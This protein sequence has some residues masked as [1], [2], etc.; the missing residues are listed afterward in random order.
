MSLNKDFFERKTNI[1]AKVICDSISEQG[2]RLTTFEIEYPRFIHSEL[3]THRTLSKNSSSSRAIPIQ[4]MIGQI[5]SN[6]ATP[7][8]WGKTKS[9]MQADGE[10]D[11]QNSAIYYWLECLSD[12]KKQVNRLSNLSLH[13]QIPNRLLEPFQMMKVVI[14]GTDWDNFFNLRIHCLSDDTEILTT[15][16]WKLIG[17]VQED[18]EVYSL[19]MINGTLEKSKVVNTVSKK[20][21][22]TAISMK[23]QSVDLLMSLK[24][25][26]VHVEDGV[27]KKSLAEDLVGKKITVPKSVKTQQV[28]D[29]TGYDYNEGFITGFALG[30][31]NVYHKKQSGNR[32]L[33]VCKGGKKSEVAL[34]K[35]K[36]ACTVVYP[37]NKVHT[38]QRTSTILEIDGKN[39]YEDFEKLLSDSSIH[40]ELPSNL[41]EQ[42]LDFLKGVFDGLLYSDGNILN[43]SGGLKFYTSSKH[44]A[45]GFQE[46]CLI[47]GY[48]AT[49]SE[50]NRIGRTSEGI[51]SLGKP[52]KITTKN[53][54][55]TCHVNLNR[56]EPTLKQPLEEVQYDGVFKCVTLDTNGT[57]YVR[58]NGKAVWTGNCDAQPEICMLAYK[59]YKA[60]EESKPIDLKVG[61]WHL[62]YVEKYDIPVT[63]SDLG[64]YEYET[65]YHVFHYDKECEHTVEQVLSLEEAIKY[66]AA[67]CA[68]VSYRTEGMTLEKADK[69]FDMLIKAEV[70]HSSPF[71]HCA[72]PIQESNYEYGVN[73]LHQSTWQD[74]VTHMNK[75]GELCSGNLRGWVQYRHTLNNNTCWK[76]DYNERMKL[77]E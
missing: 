37:N 17:N 23:G 70:V 77:F 8:Y 42:P 22:G 19:N 69:I 67:S 20:S 31:G 6:P 74:G 49:V 7:L 45:D 54:S 46:L 28:F 71:E 32:G 75:S 2:V 29:E 51:D 40:K 4:K 72:T 65:G 48:S 64:G 26:V 57:I 68:S 24:H 62:P 59:I 38:Y 13:K 44:L 36:S 18:E 53:V 55:Y 50:S 15:Q 34:D 43:R 5:E 21:L 76:F 35:F 14:T 30:N 63:Y 12:V 47:L 16:G 61:E 41:F 27:L 52:Y 58:R 3:M 56:N 60:M 66:S 39:V 11:E 73:E 1:T 9:G 33:T 10:I 25:N